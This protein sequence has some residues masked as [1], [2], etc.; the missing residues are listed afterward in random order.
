MTSWYL[1]KAQDAAPNLRVARVAAK[2]QPPGGSNSTDAR[3]GKDTMSQELVHQTFALRADVG[4]FADQHDQLH[5][6][7]YATG[8]HQ[9]FEPNSTLVS[10]VKALE[11]PRTAEELRALLLASD[12]TNPTEL[13]EVLD[14]L[15]Q[16]DI[17]ERFER[18]SEST[19]DAAYERQ[20]TFL[21]SIGSAKF[22]A[23]AAQR[24]L[25]DATVSIIGLGGLGTW[26]AQ[27]LAL[28]GVGRLRI[29]DFDRVVPSNLARQVLF[30]GADIGDLKVLAA[31]RT[32]EVTSDY[33]VAV[34]AHAVELNTSTSTAA[35][36]G[37]DLVM[38]CADQPTVDEASLLVSRL[39]FDLDLPHIVG[40]GYAGH[41]GRIGLSVRP[42][43]SACYGCVLASHERTNEYRLRQLAGD[44]SRAGTIAPVAAIVA[45][46]HAWD[47]IRILTGVGPA[48]LENRV[49]EVDLTSLEVSWREVR[50]ASDCKVCGKAKGARVA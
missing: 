42:G 44:R 27:S 24:T 43:V 29:F 49:G 6:V 25:R 12:G 31:K 32:I 1:A 14:A 18:S 37:S 28:M 34:E 47:A 15:T 21:Q 9:I 20:V 11:E 10:L 50:R 17:V 2:L 22:D 19:N 8:R 41:S 3:R 39:S 5:F 30:S 35:I 45:N 46:L 23:L 36:C 13:D 4:L 16:S 7:T 26:V 48:L 38:S 40:G 33:R